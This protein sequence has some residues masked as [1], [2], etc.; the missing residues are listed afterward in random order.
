M[1]P[2][3]SSLK[4]NVLGFFV[5]MENRDVIFLVYYKPIGASKKKKTISYEQSN[6]LIEASGK[7]RVNKLSNFRIYLKKTL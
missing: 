4:K 5:K 3:G 1:I 2:N 7:D 6:G